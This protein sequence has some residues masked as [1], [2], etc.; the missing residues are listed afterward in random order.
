MRGQGRSRTPEIPEYAHKHV[1]TGIESRETYVLR[2]CVADI[3]C[4]ASA[5]TELFPIA[6]DCLHYM[7]T[8]FGGGLGA[9]ALAWDRRFSAAYLGLPTFGNHPLRVTLPCL[10]SGEALRKR[11]RRHPDVMDVLRY[12]DAAATAR[13]ITMP[14]VCTCAL[15]DPAVPPPGQFAVYNAL[16]GPKTLFVSQAGHFAYPEEEKDQQKLFELLDRH[17][18]RTVP[19]TGQKRAPQS[20]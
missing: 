2:G 9:L 10:G 13:F 15:F 8:S 6:H 11:F 16:A 1:L 18:T 5:L 14:M 12:Y 17:A 3:W 20:S 19:R 4:A 7:G